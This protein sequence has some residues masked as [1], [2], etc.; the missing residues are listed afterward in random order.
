MKLRDGNNSKAGSTLASA[1][2]LIVIGCLSQ[3]SRAGISIPRLELRHE[4]PTLIAQAPVIQVPG[5]PGVAVSPIAAGTVVQGGFVWIS[6]GSSVAKLGASDGK[7]L[8]VYP[9]G[10]GAAGLAFDGINIW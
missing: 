1:V 5:I 3:P 10:S 7:A 6:S 2:G 8:A 9:V 4:Q